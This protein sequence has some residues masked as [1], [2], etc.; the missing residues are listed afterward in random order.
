VRGGPV[1]EDRRNELGNRIRNDG[2]RSERHGRHS[3]IERASNHIPVLI[4]HNPVVELRA[5][6]PKH[7]A[8]AL[9][10][11]KHS[12]LRD[13][14]E[15][16]ADTDST[17]HLERLPGDRER[18]PVNGLARERN[19]AFGQPSDKSLPTSPRGLQNIRVSF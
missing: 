4:S 2:K 9:S 19:A 8:D 13:K 6:N 1:H 10:P 3:V 15:A 18:S 11:K 5:T 12:L 16:R 17:S 7:L 14:Q